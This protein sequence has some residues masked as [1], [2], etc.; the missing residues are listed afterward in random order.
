[1]ENLPTEILTVIG[2]YIRMGYSKKERL[3]NLQLITTRIGS[4]SRGELMDMVK[5]N[6]DLWGFEK[7]KETKLSMMIKCKGDEKGN[8]FCKGYNEYN[9]LVKSYTYMPINFKIKDRIRQINPPPRDPNKVYK[10]NF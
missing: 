4:K 8:R 9:R 5:K 7:Y 6:P 3:E 10:L 1:M 2:E